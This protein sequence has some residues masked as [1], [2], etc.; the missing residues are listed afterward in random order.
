MNRKKLDPDSSPHAEFGAQLRKVREEQG[1]TQ[2]EVADRAGFSSSHMSAVETARKKP[3]LQVARLMDRALGTGDM[4]E[5]RWRQMNNGGLLEGFPQM[6]S[7]EAKAAEI[8]LYEVGVI[9]GLL[10]APEYAEVSAWSAVKRGVI[11]SAQAE[12]RIALIAQRQ[13][14][15]LRLPAPQIFAVLDESCLRRPMGDPRVMKAQLDRLLEFAELKNTHLQ[16]ALFDMGEHRPVSLP[17]TLLTMPDRTLVAYAESALRG[18]LERDNTYVVPLLTAY[19]QLQA[20]ALSQTDSVAMIRE[21]RKG[22][23]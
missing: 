11:T 3:T 5:R 2:E 8:R 20:E 9:P 15:L 14:S 1:L 21:L 22:T 16:I 6:V 12:E 19:Y 10:Q 7:H 17:I 18:H 13:A 4:F 23:P